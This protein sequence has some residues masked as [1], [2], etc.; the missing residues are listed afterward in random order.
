MCVRSNR[1]GEYYGRYDETGRNPGLFA[2]YLQECG[3]NSQYTMLGT[4]EQNWVAERRNRTL[5]DMVKCMLSHSTLLKFLWGEA[6]RIVVYILSSAKQVIIETTLRAND[7]KETE[8]E[9]LSCL[10]L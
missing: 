4:P 3:I 5:L 7:E 1:G 9:T 8:F 10:G 2:R 6:L